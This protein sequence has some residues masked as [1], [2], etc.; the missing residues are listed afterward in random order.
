MTREVNRLTSEQVYKLTKL[1]DE[2]GAEFSL[3]TNAALAKKA[4][5]ILGF[6]ATESNIESAR[7]I[8]GHTAQR[9]RGRFRDGA[10]NR[11][12]LEAVA[13][14]LMRLHES[15]N[16]L[17]AQLDLPTKPMVED[18]ESIAKHRASRVATAN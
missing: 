14:E 2:K 7:K 11:N 8:T 15:L 9:I 3:L 4:T 17:R 18:I 1:V 6:S 5:E 12:R 13:R 10:S 16:D